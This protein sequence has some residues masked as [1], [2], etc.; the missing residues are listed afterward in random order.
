MPALISVM[1][2]TAGL[3]SF[4]S[5]IRAIFPPSLTIRP[6]AVR[7][8]NLYRGEGETN[9]T[10]Y[11]QPIADNHMAELWSQLLQSSDSARRRRAQAGI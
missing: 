11:G 10:H 6:E 4:S 5:T 9:T 2:R 7:A 1:A 8:K 3:A